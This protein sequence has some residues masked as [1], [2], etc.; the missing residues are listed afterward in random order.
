LKGKEIMTASS[1]ASGDG[2]CWLEDHRTSESAKKMY[3]E[4]L[5]EP[6]WQDAE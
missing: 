1:Q 4:E 5:S 6:K 3:E 2:N